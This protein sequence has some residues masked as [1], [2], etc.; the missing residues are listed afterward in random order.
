MLLLLLANFVFRVL[1][2][3]TFDLPGLCMCF[4]FVAVC[5]CSVAVFVCFVSVAASTSLAFVV[6]FV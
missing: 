2:G 5:I 3:I 6:V 4:V 1:F